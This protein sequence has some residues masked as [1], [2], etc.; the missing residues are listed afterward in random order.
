MT[1]SATLN[2]LYKQLPMFHRLGAIAYKADLNN[3]NNICK[4][5]NYP[6]KNLSRCI[7]QV[8]MVRK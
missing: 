1:Y 5:L 8:Q 2:Y 6:E 4:F 7:L 3:T